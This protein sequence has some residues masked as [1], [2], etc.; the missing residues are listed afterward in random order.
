MEQKKKIDTEELM[1]DLA[2]R[3]PAEG[4]FEFAEE[5]E[6]LCYPNN[7]PSSELAVEV[8]ALDGKEGQRR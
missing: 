5:T 4:G 8:G 6:H 2:A 1:P 7:E 3:E